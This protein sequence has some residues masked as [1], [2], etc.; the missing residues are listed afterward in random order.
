M[1]TS[2]HVH[3]TQPLSSAERVP[4]LAIQTRE[5]RPECDFQVLSTLEL[6]GYHVALVAPHAP[7]TNDQLRGHPSSETMFIL[8]VT[9]KQF[10]GQMHE[11]LDRSKQKRDEIC[12][13]FGDVQVN[14]ESMEVRCSNRL[15]TLTALEF[16]LLAF[17]I[18]NPRKALSRSDLLDQVWGYDCYPCTRTVDT[19]IL[20]LRQKLEVDAACPVHFLTVYGVGY[21][22]QP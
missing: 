17:L 4:Q 20:R 11:E 13:Q 5:S 10:L 12:M 1:S 21:K 14:L 6:D 2:A 8:P 9:W 16:K 7:S 18:K 15:V 22:F 3:S 19:H